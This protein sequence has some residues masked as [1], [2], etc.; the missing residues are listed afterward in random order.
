MASLAIGSA[1]VS[2]ARIGEGARAATCAATGGGH[3]SSATRHSGSGF[4]GPRRSGRSPSLASGFAGTR[5]RDA[6]RRALSHYSR[7]S[8]V[9]TTASYVKS[10]FST[11]D[12]QDNGGRL[13]ANLDGKKILIQ[14]FMGDVYAVSNK[15]PHLN[16]SM[17]GKTALLSAKMTDDG[18]IVCP[19]HGSQFKLDS[20]EQ[21]GEWCP[22]LPDLPL[23]GKIGKGPAPLPVYQTRVTDSGDIEV[24]IDGSVGSPDSTGGSM[25]MDEEDIGML[26]GAEL[27]QLMSM[28]LADTGKGEN[29]VGA[30]GVPPAI[31]EAERKSK[32]LRRYRLGSYALA[33]SVAAAQMVSVIQAGVEAWPTWNPQAVPDIGMDILVIISGTLLWRT[34]LQNRAES[35]KTIWAK[36]RTRE[37]S[38]KRAEAG[39]GD[40]L[41][42]SRM[43]K[44]KTKD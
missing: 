34:E 39:L 17:Q 44:K 9:M 24:D 40:T 18:C 32:P 11:Q 22:N 7:R 8:Q 19:A 1:A 6:P 27:Q 41:W 13:V 12:L 25:S 16:L 37:E 3:A 31:I 35:L 21:V 29:V 4:G 5:V 33:S 28:P 2:V 30:E 23:V 10:G 38:L 14:D 42:T 15:C 26:R 43:R 20:G 36:A